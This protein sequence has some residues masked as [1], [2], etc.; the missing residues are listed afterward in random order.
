MQ[1]YTKPHVVFNRVDS[2]SRKLFPL[3]FLV[4]NLVYWYGYMY[5][6]SDVHDID[7]IS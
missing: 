1:I 6:L 2:C 4:L 5:V 3:T 7:S